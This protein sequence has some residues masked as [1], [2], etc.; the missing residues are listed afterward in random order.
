VYIMDAVYTSP[1]VYS[2]TDSMLVTAFNNNPNILN[3]KNDYSIHGKRKTET[4]V[5]IPVHYR[6]AID[7]KPLRY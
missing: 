4:N 6:F 1:D 7:H 5:E 2:L 3:L